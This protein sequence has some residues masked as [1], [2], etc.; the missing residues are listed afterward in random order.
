MVKQVKDAGGNAVPLLGYK[1]NGA[2]KL[3]Y[4]SSVANTALVSSK[5]ISVTATTNCFIEV[6]GVATANS[7]F[8]LGAVP[9]DFT[10]GAERNS[11]NLSV[12]GESTGTLYVSERD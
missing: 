9:Y 12:L 4:T 3:T 10:L 1:L 2:T 7:H 5:V 11:A 8:L 6:G